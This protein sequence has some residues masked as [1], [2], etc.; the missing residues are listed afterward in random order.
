MARL[1]KIWKN[2]VKVDG[3]SWGVFAVF[4]PFVEGILLCFRETH[5]NEIMTHFDE[6]KL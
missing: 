5:V 3:K 1:P 6:I 2:D 4:L